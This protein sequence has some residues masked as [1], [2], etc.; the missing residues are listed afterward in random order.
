[1][2]RRRFVVRT[3][4]VVALFGGW[5]AANVVPLDF[6]EVRPGDPIEV[7]PRL[8]I[9]TA[10]D[11]PAKGRV[12]FLTVRI[13]R[14]LS[15]VEAVTGWLQGPVDVFTEKTLFGDESPVESRQRGQVE[16]DDAKTLATVVAFRRLGLPLVARGTRIVDIAP[17]APA[18]LVL[19][20][21]DVITAVDGHP[22][23]IAGDVS[24]ALRTH[25][26]DDIVTLKLSTGRLVPV[27]L[28]GDPEG[29]RA[30]L[31]LHL[32]TVSCRPAFRV[33]VE[34]GGLLGPSGGLAMTL[35]ILDRLS[36]GELLGPGAVAVTG[37]IEADGSV[38]PIGGIK[39]KTIAARRAGAKLFL[40]P[41]EELNEAR[42]HAGR[43]PVVG[44]HRLEDA[45]LALVQHD[46]TPLP[47]EPA[48][49]AVNQTE[50]SA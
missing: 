17:D 41:T 49:P 40:V 20:P 3:V 29:G 25:R 14:R 23:C 4:V 21:G 10:H 42:R 28:V 48:A 46:G 12:L 39:Q 38:G 34:T 37:T 35:S 11:H 5:I 31:G 16:I 45:L 47:A 33:D 15:A 13:R 32:T 43:L 19:R 9:A 8:S 6:A 26:A 44:V 27:A 1:M 7:G 50:R 18:A 36:A 30:V 2:G 24:E 22:I